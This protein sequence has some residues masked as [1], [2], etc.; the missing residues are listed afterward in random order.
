MKIDVEAE[1]GKK[2]RKGR[3]TPSGINKCYEKEEIKKNENY[4][5]KNTNI[6]TKD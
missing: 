4:R 1:T 5:K 2:G 6:G 3:K